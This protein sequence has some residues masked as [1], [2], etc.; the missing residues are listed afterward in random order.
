MSSSRVFAACSAAV[1]APFA[2]HAPAHAQARPGA[3]RPVRLI[4]PYPAGGGTDIVVRALS[5]KLA[6]NLGQHVVV[7]NRPGAGSVIGVDLA[8]KSQPDGHTLLFANLA[9]AINATLLPKLPYDPHKDLTPITLV[10]IQPHILVV[11]PALQ[12]STVKELIALARQRPRQINYA[13]SGIGTGPHL[14]AAMFASM[15]AIEMTHVPYK[16]AAPALT[17]VIGAHAQIM[18]ATLVSASSHVQ[19]ARLRALAVT[20]AKR[21][22]AVPAVPT[23]AEAGVPNY[24][25]VAWYVLLAR[26]G[27]PAQLLA[28][29]REATSRSLSDPGVR[30][31]LNNDGAEIVGNTPDEAARFLRSEIARWGAVIRTAGVK[32]E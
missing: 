26:S 12:A 19:N 9:F 22:Q 2:W 7:D 4:V 21:A 13:S 25:A 1:L 20:S 24:E 6:E 14:A 3:D 27:T 29:I 11:H 30:E 23:I 8:A 17:D 15:T 10:A 28:R 31:R 16:G 32:A 5:Q 18:F